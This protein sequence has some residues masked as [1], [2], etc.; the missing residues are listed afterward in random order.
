MRKRLQKT[1]PGTVTFILGMIGGCILLAVIFISSWIAV[2]TGNTSGDGGEIIVVIIS[3][4]AVLVYGVTA[5][6]NYLVDKLNEDEE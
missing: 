5:V 2:L 6:W 3:G 4:F 1:T